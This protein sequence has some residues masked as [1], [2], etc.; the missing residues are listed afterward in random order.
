M[1]S[2]SDGD[3]EWL[4]QYVLDTACYTGGPT[5]MRTRHG[6]NLCSGG[7]VDHFLTDHVHG[8]EIAS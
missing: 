3:V 1:D 5:Y 8:V 7:I 6:T 2:D 4:G